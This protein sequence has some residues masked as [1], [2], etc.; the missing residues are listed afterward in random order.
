MLGFNKKGDWDYLMDMTPPT[1]GCNGESCG[2]DNPCDSGCHC[3]G[4]S[5]GGDWEGNC[6]GGGNMGHQLYSDSN[7]CPCPGDSTAVLPACCE[8]DEEW[9]DRERMYSVGQGGGM[10]GAQLF[11]CPP[12]SYACP[13]GSACLPGC[14]KY[15]DPDG[16][17]CL[18]GNCS[19]GEMKMVAQNFI[20]MY[21]PG[22]NGSIM[23]V[24]DCVANGL[25]S[26]GCQETCCYGMGEVGS[27]CMNIV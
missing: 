3:V 4:G 25:H 26:T 22:Y 5:S 27:C 20:D 13:G 19:A 9:D 24:L 10:G 6:D 21:M 12:G 7:G 23:S 17:Q 16:E 11:G 8:P 18:G 15:H 14:K 1:A 2:R